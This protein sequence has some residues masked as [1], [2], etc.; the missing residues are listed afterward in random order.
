MTPAAFRQRARHEALRYGSDPW[1]FVRELLQNARDAGAGRVAFSADER[2]GVSRITC[3][4]DGAGMTFE[5]ARRYL[6][7][8]YASSKERDRGAA[9]RFGVGFWAVLRFEPSRLVVRSWPAGGAPWEVELDGEL[10]RMDVRTPSARPGTG[11]EIVLERDALDGDLSRR[12]RDA[13]WQSARFLQRVDD[14]RRALEVRVN[15][16][17]VNAAF[18]LPAPSASFRKGRLRGVVALGAEARVELFAKGLRVRAASTVEDLLSVDGSSGLTR[19]RFP[20][21]ADGVAPQAILDGEDVEPLLARADVRETPALRRL[22]ALAQDELR[23]LVERQLDAARPRSWRRRT[24]PVVAGIAAGLVL[25]GLAG[26]VARRRLSPPAPSAVPAV[27]LAAAPLVEG[28]EAFDTAYRDFHLRYAGPRVEQA[29]ERRPPVA[30]RYEPRSAFVYFAALVLE[31]PFERPPAPIAA[32]AYEG[33]ACD[34]TCL[35]VQLQIDDGPGGVRVPVPTGFRIDPERV[36][37]DGR[38]VA[39]RATAAG[40]PLVQLAARSRGLLTYAVRPAADPRWMPSPAGATPALLAEAAERIGARPAPERLDAATDWVRAHI[41]YSASDATVERHRQARASGHDTLAAALTVGAADCDV[42][43]AV[44]TT[45][46]QAVDV[47]AR[48]AI[49]YVGADG[50]ALAPPHAWVEVRAGTGWKV[51]DASE[52]GAP[53]GRG[54]TRARARPRLHPAPRPRGSA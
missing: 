39:L 15:G 5:H 40:E 28:G 30:L 12:V 49:G 10:T 32:A 33:P 7:A 37:L 44:L 4:D 3:D 36:R 52:G 34:H 41:A 51:V 26:V 6:F 43:N 18:D 47:P 16:E 24:A 25:L 53:A 38:A 50:A 31:R 22:V 21:L 1:I 45:L 13:A 17:A 46:L 29:A 11:T 54:S 14:R 19:V 20:A 23:R 8:L 9:G 35:T 2:G 48:L 42:Q 27:S